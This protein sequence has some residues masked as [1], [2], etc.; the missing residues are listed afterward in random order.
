MATS[1]EFPSEF[2]AYTR[3]NNQPEYIFYS[4]GISQ[5]EYAHYTLEFFIDKTKPTT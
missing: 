1:T 4:E 3:K 5:P 2:I